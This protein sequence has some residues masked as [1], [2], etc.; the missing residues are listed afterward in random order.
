M[1]ALTGEAR[2][3]FDYR[4]RRVQ[5]VT[6]LSFIVEDSNG[7]VE[8]MV[9]QIAPSFEGEIVAQKS[10]CATRQTSRR[11][12]L[13]AEIAGFMSGDVIHRLAFGASRSS[14][15]FTVQTMCKTVSV[16]AIFTAAQAV[17]SLHSSGS[18]YSSRRTTGIFIDFGEGAFHTTLTYKNMPPPKSAR[19]LT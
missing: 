6:A 7:Q 13:E 12:S 5:P 4:L 17:P 2:G 15:D 19:V 3:T 9:G 16:P 8:N 10:V 14:I 1:Q 18:L 11:I